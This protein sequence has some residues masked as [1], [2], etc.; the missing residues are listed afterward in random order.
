MIPT[1]PTNLFK[2][3]HDLKSGLGPMAEYDGRG[4]YRARQTGADGPIELDACDYG[5]LLAGLNLAGRR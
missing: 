1:T 5:A 2:L 3:G 4:L